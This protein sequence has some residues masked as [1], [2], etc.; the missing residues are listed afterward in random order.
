MKIG[1]KINSNPKEHVQTG[2]A[3]HARHH[4][5]AKIQ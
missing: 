3:S 1:T 5:V 4:P 2:L